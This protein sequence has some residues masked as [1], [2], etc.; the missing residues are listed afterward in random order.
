MGAERSL[1]LIYLVLGIVTG[2]LSNYWNMTISIAVGIVLYLAS[3]FIIRQIATE[4]KK[5][6]WYVLNTLLTFVLVWLVTWIF[7]FNL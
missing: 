2:V 5:S 4:R 7:L 1:T 6:S 3:F